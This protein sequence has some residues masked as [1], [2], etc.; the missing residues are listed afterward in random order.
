MADVF[1]INKRKQI[2]ARIRSKNTTPEQRVKKALKLLGKS[3][4]TYY[5][6][7]PGRP[8]IVIKDSKLAL[9]VHGC[10][11][12]QHMGCT[13]NFTPKSNKAYWVPK[14]AR[15]VERFREVQ[16]DLRRMNWKVKVVWECQTKKQDRLEKLLSKYM[17]QSE[18]LNAV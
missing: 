15:N 6:S 10:F 16:R 9:F 3:F 5:S 14:L 11:W 18:A 7:L 17:V 12:H 8:D 1:S 4:K 13:R 2:M